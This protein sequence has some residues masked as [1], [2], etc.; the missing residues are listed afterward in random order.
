MIAMTGSCWLSDANDDEPCWGEFEYQFIGDTDLG[1][2]VGVWSC[3][4][5]RECWDYGS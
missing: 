3:E 5:H 2:E 4:G 1:D